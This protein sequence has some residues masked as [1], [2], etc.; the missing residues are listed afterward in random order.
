MSVLKRLLATLFF[1]FIF[2]SCSGTKV[3]DSWT[4]QTYQGKIQNV[5]IIGIAKMILTA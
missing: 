1:G 5:Y 4:S 2:I 3:S